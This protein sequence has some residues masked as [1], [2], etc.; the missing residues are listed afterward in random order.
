MRLT[1]N[2]LLKCG[3]PARIPVG[4]PD[5]EIEGAF[6]DSREPVPGA[7]FVGVRGVHAA[8]TGRSRPW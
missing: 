7:L 1:V 8:A 5:V 3:V 6:V 2:D 4:K